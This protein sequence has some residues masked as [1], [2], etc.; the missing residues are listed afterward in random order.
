MF[1][2]GGSEELRGACLGAPAPCE[3]SAPK[4]TRALEK[5]RGPPAVARPVGALGQG[6]PAPCSRLA[7]A[8]AGRSS[9]AGLPGCVCRFS[10]GLGPALLRGV[11]SAPAVAVGRTGSGPSRAPPPPTDRQALQAPLDPF[12]FRRLASGGKETPGWG[13]GPLEHGLVSLL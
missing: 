2:S 12:S 7:A 6:G 8:A 5:S 11:R 9:Q 13:W 4:G 1:A 10:A 3:S